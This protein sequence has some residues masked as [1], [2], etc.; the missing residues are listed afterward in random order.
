[1]YNTVGYSL[2]LVTFMVNP[3]IRFTLGGDSVKRLGLYPKV[4]GYHVGRL[5][6]TAT[7]RGRATRRR[8][9]TYSGTGG[10]VFR[11]CFSALSFPI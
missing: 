7:T 4:N 1:M 8:R 5:V 6:I 10:A 9:R 11:D 2:R 3:I